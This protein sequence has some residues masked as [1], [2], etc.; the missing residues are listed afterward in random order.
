[1]QTQ[2]TLV[3]HLLD[4]ETV[5]DVSTLQIFNDI[6]FTNDFKLC[7]TQDYLKTI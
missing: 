4:S 6:F 5:W 3:D 2:S 7:F 1:M